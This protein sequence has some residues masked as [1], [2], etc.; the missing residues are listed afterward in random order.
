ML[1]KEV[2]D[3]MRTLITRIEKYTERLHELKDISAMIAE[4]KEVPVYVATEKHRIRINDED[5]DTAST[6]IATGVLVNLA[7]DATEKSLEV[8][9]EALKALVLEDYSTLT[10]EAVDLLERCGVEVYEHID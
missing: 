1:K 9:R 4:E 8:Y 6:S 2:C 10:T 5:T 7:Y 3:A